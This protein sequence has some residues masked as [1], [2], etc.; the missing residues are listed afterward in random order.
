P[1]SSHSRSAILIQMQD[2]PIVP[3]RTAQ[4]AAA[5]CPEGKRFGHPIEQ[6]AP[7]NIARVLTGALIHR[8]PDLVVPAH[9]MSTAHLIAEETGK[10][11]DL[12]P[13][14]LENLTVR[15]ARIAE[16]EVI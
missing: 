12:R 11:K 16:D 1:K 4:V 2:Q 3:A 8:L 5:L 15:Q 14:D 9:V 13:T 7:L 10:Q 6:I